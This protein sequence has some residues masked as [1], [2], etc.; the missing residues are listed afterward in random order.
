VL[1]SGVLAAETDGRFHKLV[2]TLGRAK[3]LSVRARR[4]YY[5]LKPGNRVQVGEIGN[6]MKLGE[7]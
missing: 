3:K 4:G 5:A 7:M 1:D 6:A 2:V